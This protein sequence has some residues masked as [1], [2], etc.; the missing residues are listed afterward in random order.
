[1]IVWMKNLFKDIIYFVYRRRLVKELNR[2]KIMPSHVGL[3]LDGNRRYAKQQGFK[4]VSKGHRLGAD[5]IDEVLSW[6]EDLGIHM[7]TLWALSTENLRRES[8]E[9][10]DLLKII[11]VKI[12]EIAEDPR[13]HQ[14]RMKIKSLGKFDLLPVSTQKVLTEAEYATKDY[15]NFHL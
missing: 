3:I 4:E 5:K 6:C 13:T 14:R 7:I 2:N 10:S 9:I 11:E 1:M 8:S 15:D 12:T